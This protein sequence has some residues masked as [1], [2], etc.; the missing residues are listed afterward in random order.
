MRAWLRGGRQRCN[1]S[2]KR[3]R[4]VRLIDFKMPGANI[5]HVTWEWKFEPPARNGDRADM[6]FVVNGVPVAI[7]AFLVPRRLLL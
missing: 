5:V 3:R 1:E 7:G 6:M 4:Q 2:G